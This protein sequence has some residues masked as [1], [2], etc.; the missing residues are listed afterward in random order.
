MS[1][2]FLAVRL[3]QRAAGSGRPRAG[4]A[5]ML[6]CVVSRVSSHHAFRL[7][8]QHAAVLD[9]ELRQCLV[10]SLMQMSSKKLVASVVLLPL[11]FKVCVCVCAV[12]CCGR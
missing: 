2:F 9:P 8:D 6:R 5:T 7:L 1:G 3:Q 11:C 12:L 4:S 10:K